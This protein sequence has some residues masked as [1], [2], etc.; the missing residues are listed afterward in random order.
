MEV[1]VVNEN[2]AKLNWYVRS[3]EKTHLKIKG[4]FTKYFVQFWTLFNKF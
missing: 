4:I 1:K 2:I 3:H